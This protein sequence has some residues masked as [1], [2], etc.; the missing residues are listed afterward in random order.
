VASEQTCNAPRAERR[1]LSAVRSD[2]LSHALSHFAHEAA[3][4]AESPAFRAPFFIEGM[5]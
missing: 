1:N 4:F 2:Y 5:E 3:G